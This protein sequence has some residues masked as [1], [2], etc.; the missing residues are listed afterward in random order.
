M[1]KFRPLLERMLYEEVEQYIES[2][3]EE[4]RQSYGTLEEIASEIYES[5][6]EQLLNLVF[7]EE[8]DWLRCRIE[9]LLVHYR[10]W[11]ENPFGISEAGEWTLGEEKYIE[12]RTPSGYIKIL[13]DKFE[14]FKNLMYEMGKKW[15]VRLESVIPKSKKIKRF[16]DLH[17]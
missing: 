10:W 5:R 9:D 4:L 8:R 15:K 11:L 2:K 16:K 12:A 6:K 7:R 14:E 13:P 3:I 1:G 17:N